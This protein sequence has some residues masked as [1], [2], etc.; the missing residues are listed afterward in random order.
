M[1]DPTVYAIMTNHEH[2]D[3]NYE[4][5]LIYMVKVL[6]DHNKVL[7]DQLMFQTNIAAN[8]RTTWFYINQLPLHLPY[9]LVLR[10]KK[11]R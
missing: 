8:R 2:G 11:K 9:R 3:I 5:A 7:F 6:H 10:R 1:N 4:Q